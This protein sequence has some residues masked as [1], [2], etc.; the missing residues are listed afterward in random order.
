MKILLQLILIF[1]SIIAFAA[2]DSFNVVLKNKTLTSQIP[3]ISKIYNKPV[4]IDNSAANI[5]M[6]LSAKNVSAVE[7]K[8]IISKA[9]SLSGIAII[10]TEQGVTFLPA[11]DAMKSSIETYKNEIKNPMPERMA[12]LILDLPKNL[13]AVQMEKYLRSLYSRDGSMYANDQRNQLVITDWTSNLV[14]LKDVAL[15][16]ERVKTK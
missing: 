10:E 1:S 15:K 11:R 16:S 13:N 8:N 14:R 7:A 3:L 9:L 12:T 4:I 6:T 2:T 5:K